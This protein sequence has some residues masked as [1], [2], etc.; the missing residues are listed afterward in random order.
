MMSGVFDDISLD[1]KGK[2]YVIPADRVLGAVAR[3]EQHITLHEIFQYAERGAAPMGILAQAYGSVLRYAGARISNDEVYD[4]MFEDGQ[5][6]AAVSDSLNGLL[7]MM[8]PK[9]QKEPAKEHKPGNSR[10][11]VKNSSRNSTKR[12][13]GTAG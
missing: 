6:M 11:A 12:R 3:I 7:N 2:T 1:W 4:G 9:S 8:L 10:K 5:S 13:S